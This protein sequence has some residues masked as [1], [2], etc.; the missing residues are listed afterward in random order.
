MPTRPQAIE[1]RR[2]TPLTFSHLHDV[3]VSERLLA[4]SLLGDPGA[5]LGGLDGVNVE[6][7]P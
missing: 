2:I 1:G 6:G 7:S 5:W 3:G 4:L